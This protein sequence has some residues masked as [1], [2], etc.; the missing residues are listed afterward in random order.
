[1]LPRSL[2]AFLAAFVFG[3]MLSPGQTINPADY[4]N[5]TLRLKAEDLTYANNAAV[6]AW[7]SFTAGGTATPTFIANDARFNNKPVVRLDGVD[8][9]LKFPSANTNARTIFAVVTLESAAGSLAGLIG[10]GDDKL[11]LRRNGTANFYR[12]PLQGQD[13]NDFSGVVTGGN[14]FVNNVASGGCTAGAAHIV[15]AVAGANQTYTNFWIGSAST[16]LGRYWNGSIAEIIVYDGVL[17]QT[18]LER[19]GWYLQNKYNI[20]GSTYPAPTPQITSYTAAA[21][22]ITASTGVLSTAGAAVTL[23]WNVAN[24][25]TVSIN[26]GALT[27]PGSATGSVSVSP[28]VTT[29]YTLTATNTAGTLTRSVTVYIGLT[30]QPLVLN[31]FLA[32]NGS[33]VLDEDGTKQDWIELYNPN[34]FAVSANGWQ[35]VDGVTAWI[36]P[37]ATIEGGAYPLVF[38]SAKNRV[39]PAAPLH[40]NFNLGKSG[41]YLALKKPDGSIAA[42]FTPAYP[43]QRTDVS[44]GLSGGVAVYFPTPT[45]GAANG[46]T[47]VSGF[48]ADTDFTVKRGFFSTMQTVAISCPTAGAAIKYTLDNSTPTDTNGLVYSAPLSINTTTVLRARA[49]KAGLLASNTDTQ[50]YVFVS[51]VPNQVYAT[52]PAGWPAPGAAQLNGQT[53]RYGFQPALKAQYTVQQL[54]DAL[55]Q[56]PSLSIV[57]DQ[58]NLTDQTTGIYS[59]ADQKGDAWER[60][61]SVEYMPPG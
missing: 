51:D 23:A 41:E 11:N 53:M 37:N 39:N 32:D 4:G 2:L 48:V 44:C 34:P 60:A 17:T 18:G 61:A 21:G 36:F 58:P 46:S 15:M 45:P 33:S 3:A 8:D 12:S 20:A 24:A 5:I 9:V 38:A 6:T 1:M 10:R 22:G 35:L 56:V 47:T 54:T 50:S 42:E 16:A 52:A 49:F 27:S 55:N 43:V 25:T 13:T 30:G 40:T 19:V 26:N 59:N 14:L 31:E 57:T 28:S 29:T 7:G